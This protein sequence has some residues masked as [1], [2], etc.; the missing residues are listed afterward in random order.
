MTS[1]PG[2]TRTR[3]HVLA[4]LSINYVER[5]LLLCGCSAQRIHS[6]YGYDLIVSSFN[7]QGEIEGGHVYFQVKATD[8]LPLLADGKTISWVVSRRDLRLWL[9]EGYPVILVVYD[10]RRDK[11]FWLQ[12]QSH[13]AQYSPADLFLAGLTINVHLPMTNRLD[14]RSIQGIVQRK[15]AF[16]ATLEGRTF[17]DVGTP[18]QILQ[19][20]SYV[21]GPRIQGSS[22]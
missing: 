10:G 4:D 13:F 12:V 22:C 15:N 8:N 9:T 5:R 6:D 18:L 2:K 1:P 11:G 20:A 19:P 7:A 3:E 14:R 21:L 16:H 17:P